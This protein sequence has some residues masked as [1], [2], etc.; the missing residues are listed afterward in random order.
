MV[1]IDVYDE[2]T[3]TYELLQ[4]KRPD[5]TGAQRIFLNLTKKYLGNKKDLII[6]DFCCGTGNNTL[7]VSKILSINTSTLIDV[8]QKFLDIAKKSNIKSRE[9]DLICSDILKVDLHQEYDAIISMFSY[10]HVPNKDKN[11]YIEIVKKSLG[12]E[13]I[14]LLGE[15]YSPD[16]ETTLKYYNFLLNSISE[17]IRTPELERFLDQTAKSD[18]FEYKV[19][20]QFTHNLLISAGFTLLEGSKVW[21]HESP[22][23]SDVGTF[24]EIW[25]ITK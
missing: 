24:V 15:I 3:D 13:G 11:K 21:P 25:K 22:F 17:Q 19:S 16:K 8:N 7:L 18:D 9:L 6:A 12:T 20:R 5:Y 23:D 4:N 14:L 2:S 1:D 10:H